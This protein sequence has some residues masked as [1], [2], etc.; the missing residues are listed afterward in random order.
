MT[1]ILRIQGGQPLQGEITA[2]GAKNSVTKLLVASLLSDKLCLFRNVPNIG[3]VKITVD[4]CREIGSKITWDQQDK[5]ISIQTQELKT[6]YIPQRYSG[7]NRIPILMIGALVG[8]TDE[9][10]IVP[11]VGGDLI[12][13]R[14]VDLHTH[15]LEK[16]GAKIEYRVMKTEG[17]YLASAH[18]GL[19]GTTI[20]LNYPSVGATE[21]TLLAAVH[22][23]GVTTIHNAAMEP[24]IIDLILFLQKLGVYVQI[25]PNRTI[26]VQKTCTFHEVEHTVPADRNEVASYAMAAISTQG[27]V[28][29]K[30]AHHL[31]ML[32]FLNALQS[33]GGR[34][35]VFSDGIEFFYDKPLRGGVHLETDVHPGFMTDWQQP[36]TVLLTQA[37]GLSVLHETVYENRFGYTHT[38]RFMG[39]D[40][41]SFTNCLG[42]LPCRFV[43]QNHVHSI[44][45]RG[46]TPLHGQEISIPDLRAGFAYIVAALT[47]SNET[48]ITK[49]ADF[50][51]RGYE[52]LV[53]KLQSIGA[54]IQK[55]A[56]HPLCHAPI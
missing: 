40:I 12:G 2:A 18:H 26:Q 1:H 55:E 32:S 5:T 56:L 19:K 48:V 34:F 31:P 3:E 53:R 28:M 35:R 44:V 16:L 8:R 47:A 10:I 54:Q 27:R 52:D 30:G 41:Q 45:V 21:N 15:A 7:S 9:S 17:A 51:D 50:L 36:F 4:L 49:N 20:H 37:V 39:A 43:H 14:P 22:A 24:E 29:I 42:S 13:Q 38:L 23:Q 46:P 11:T 25:L 33:I 6:T